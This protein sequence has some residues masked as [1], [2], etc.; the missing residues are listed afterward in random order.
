LSAAAVIPIEKEPGPVIIGIDKGLGTG[1]L[2][3]Y[4]FHDD[5]TEA[6]RYENDR[7]LPG[8]LAAGGLA[9]RARR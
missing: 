6:V 8:K 1:R 9:A 3:S 4:I 5:A 2:E 7:F